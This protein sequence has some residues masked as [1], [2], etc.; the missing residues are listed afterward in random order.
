MINRNSASTG[1]ELGYGEG[2]RVSHFRYGEGTVVKI[3]KGSKDKQ[4]T[5]VFDEAGQ[6][7]MYAGFAKLTKI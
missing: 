3:E 6:K 2:D 5:V 7:I 4:V 1:T